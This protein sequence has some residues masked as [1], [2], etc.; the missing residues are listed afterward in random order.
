MQGNNLFCQARFW[1]PTGLGNRLFSW[2]RATVYSHQTG[3]QMLSSGW[4]HVRGGSIIRGGI[5]YSDA[6]RKILLFDNFHAGKKEIS[7]L[8]KMLVRR[9]ATKVDVNTLPDAWKLQRQQNLLVS[10]EGHLAHEFDDLWAYSEEVYSALREITNKKWLK[11]ADESPVPFIGINVR[12]GNDFRKVAAGTDLVGKP[13]YLQTPL[14]WY[15]DTLSTIRRE[16]AIELPA[17]VISDG[18]SSDL[19]PL[20]DLPATSL[21]S[22]KSAIADLLLLSKSSVLLGAGRSSFSAWASF[23]GKMPTVTIPGS[24]LQSFHVS[25]DLNRHYVGEFDNESDNTEALKFIKSTLRLPT[26]V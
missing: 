13:G 4:A 17:V 2:A 26:T 15:V 10:F 7:G 14:Q 5:N 1:R 18:T 20:L 3:A 24:N 6:I 25:E 12:M 19:K 21:G 11:E 22:T 16:L 23:L 9:S 8:K